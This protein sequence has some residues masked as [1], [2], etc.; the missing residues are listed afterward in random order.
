MFLG[1]YNLAEN[2][3]GVTPDPWFLYQGQT[4]REAWASL[5]YG[6]QANRGFM[7]LIAPP[8][9]GKTTLLFLL[10]ERMRKQARTVFLFQPPCDSQELLR[11]L[12][13]DLGIIPAGDRAT[14]H[15]QLN[16]AL[17]NEAQ[18]GRSLLLILDEAQNLDEPV[19]E[20]IR[21]LSNFETAHAKLLQ[22]ILAGQP[23]LA[24]KLSAPGMEQLRQRVS[25]I[26]RL[27]PFDTLEVSQYIRHRLEVAGYAGSPLFTQEALEIIARAS[28]GIPRRINNLC[29]NALSIG[30]AL[31]QKMING[32]VV[33]EAIADLELETPSTLSESRPEEHRP[34]K[35]SVPPNF[36][37]LAQQTLTFGKV[38]LRV[39]TVML[40]LGLGLIFL[41][42]RWAAPEVE[43]PR[44]SRPASAEPVPVAPLSPVD[45]VSSTAIT[46]VLD[47][48]GTDSRTR[49]IVVVETS[50]NLFRISLRYLGAYNPQLLKQI[51]ALNPR[52]L[53]PNHIEIGQEIRLPLEAAQESS[54]RER[55]VVT[56]STP[57]KQ[58]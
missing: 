47:S 3:F 52:L 45:P 40:A 38:A 34:E 56:T 15:Q 24:R 12:L 43:L 10:L 29:F 20:T 53:D 48:A 44:A 36:H 32:A 25:I 7:T 51:R 42:A 1:Y 49:S 30:F 58:P 33:E 54:R 57:R 31:R 19:L 18:M 13:Y 14:M 39:A 35:Q 11:H 9:M 55:E 4:H 27:E 6:V 16:Q 5:I 26:S 21:L 50:Q 17:L 41:S 8:G 23:Q 46:P 22:I 37:L 2:P 28:K